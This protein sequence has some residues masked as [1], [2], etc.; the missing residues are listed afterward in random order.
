MD[1]N[2]EILKIRKQ[3]Y[4]EQEYCLRVIDSCETCSQMEAALRLVINTNR[5]WCFMIERFS[6]NNLICRFIY[7]PLLHD[8]VKSIY[9]SLST[10]FRSR[11]DIL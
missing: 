1:I 11:F 4:S 8:F 5:R 10:D 2:Q 7:A 6:E 9:K 3:V